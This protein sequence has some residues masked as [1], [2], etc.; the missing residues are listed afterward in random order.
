MTNSQKF[1]NLLNLSIDSTYE[2]RRKST[3]LETGYNPL[4]GLWEL[5]IKY[6]GDFSPISQIAEFYSILLNNFAIILIK[7]ENLN[8]LSELTNVEY[9]EKPKNLFFALDEGRKASCVSPLRLPEYNLSGEGVLIAIIDSGIDIYNN[10]FRNPDGSTRI[11]SLWDQSISGNP[12]EGYYLGSEYSEDDINQ[13]LENDTILPPIPGEDISGHGTAVAGVAAGNGINSDGRF[14]G[15]APLSKLIIVKMAPG[16]EGGFPRT[17]QLMQ[18]VDYAIRM[19][20]KYSMPVAVNLSFGNNYGPHNNDFLL[21]Q[22]LNDISFFWK[23]SIVIGT[24]NEGESRTHTSIK[25]EQSQVKTIRLSVGENEPS[26]N[27]Q[28]WKNYADDISLTIISPSGSIYVVPLNQPDVHRT[29]LEDTRLL[30]YVGEPAPFTAQQ[31]LFIEFLPSNSYI[32]TGEWRFSITGLNIV[33]GNINLWLPAQNA[34]SS[35]TG[36]L[37]PTAE[38]SLTVPS[39]AQRLISVGAYDSR[40][41]RFAGFSGRGSSSLNKPDLVAPGVNINAPTPNNSYESFSGTSIAA[42]FVTGAAALLMEWGIVNGNDPYLYG[43]KIKAYL[44][45]G[46]RRLPFE[47][48]YPNPRLG[49]GALCVSESIKSI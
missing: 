43:E 47:N 6:S 40:T 16:L 15:V 24:G 17:T 8:P 36:F 21:E 34:I 42:P 20:L 1:E 14:S 23:S 28:L 35:S 46:A 48:E 31:E 22:F 7:E 32:N 5:I 11:L 2:E 44:I 41:N 26:L 30:M 25:L 4:S 3:E 10:D 27:L 13:I 38:L 49:W 37:E 29:N 19:G 39:T 45:S 12:P 9:V 18:G 33:S